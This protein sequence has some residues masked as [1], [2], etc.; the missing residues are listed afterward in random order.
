MLAT[1]R[2]NRL[3]DGHINHA[4]LLDEGL[5]RPALGR[6]HGNRHHGRAGHDGQTGGSGLVFAHLAT[7]HTCAF[8]EHDDPDALVQQTLALLHHLVEGARTLGPVDVNHVQRTNGPA[9][10]RHLQQLLL[11][12]IGQRTRHDGR[13]QESLI[14][15]LVLD[16]QHHTLAPIRRQVFHALHTVPDTHDDAGAVHRQF[17]PGTRHAIGLV[18]RATDPLG[19][20]HTK[21]IGNNG[22]SHP[23]H[24]EDGT[25]QGHEGN[26]WQGSITP[27]RRTK[28]ARNIAASAEFSS[29]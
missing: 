21:G 15:G 26:R 18:G 29:S 4:R 6:C 2:R 1:G 28:S 14:G 22:D 24:V 13:H 12:H 25:N 20:Q 10:E 17:E 19:Q 16:Q 8:W 23:Q 3:A 9:K 11:E 5:A 7:V 27:A